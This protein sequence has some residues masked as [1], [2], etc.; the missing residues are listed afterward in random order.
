MIEKKVIPKHWKI[1]E[2]GQ[3]C[4]LKN[5]FAFKSINYTNEGV[6]VIR[7]SDINGGIVS[8]N[9]AIRVVANNEY[10]NYLVENNDI[11]V[12]MSIWPSTRI[13][14]ED[15]FVELLKNTFEKFHSPFCS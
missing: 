1:K 2:L 11:L 8:S 5:G 13:A 6:P 12:A 3:V 14:L 15:K 7:I 4:K 10:E 9:K